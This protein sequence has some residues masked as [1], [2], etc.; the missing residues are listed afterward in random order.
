MV[1]LVEYQFHMFQTERIENPVFVES[2]SYLE[3]LKNH[4]YR[5][6]NNVSS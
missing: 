4:S 2:F 1:R 5:S 6:L 3:Y